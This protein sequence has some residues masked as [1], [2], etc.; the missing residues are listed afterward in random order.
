ML[1][2]VCV[3]MCVLC[4]CMSVHTH[5]RA[6]VCMY[7]Y[8]RPCVRVLFTSSPDANALVTQGGTEGH[9]EEPMGICKRF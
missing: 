2:D 6:C 1:A 9:L 5:M 4:V 3:Y 7:V 8:V